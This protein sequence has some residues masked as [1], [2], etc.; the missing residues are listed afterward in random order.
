MNDEG[1]HARVTKVHDA[2]T[3]DVK[4]VLCGRKMRDIPFN[5]ITKV[6]ETD[7]RPK[8]GG[9][10]EIIA[11]NEASCSPNYICNLCNRQVHDVNVGGEVVCD[12]CEQWFHLRCLNKTRSWAQRL[13]SFLCKNCLSKTHANNTSDPT[14][15]VM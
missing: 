8:R 9:I 4:Y 11:S 3:A 7:K 13:E 10:R 12:G 6:V 14:E 2:G 5:Y 1:G 15:K